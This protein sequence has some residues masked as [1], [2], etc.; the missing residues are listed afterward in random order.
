[1]AYADFIKGMDLSSF[2]AIEDHN[3]KFYDMNGNEIT[4]VFAFLAEKK[5]VNYVRLRLWNNPTLSF[6]AGDYCNLAHTLLIAPRIIGAGMKFLLDFHYSD[7]WAD[8]E[9][10]TKPE[11]WKDLSYDDLKQAMYDY[12]VEVLTALNEV[13]AFPDMVQVGNEISGGLLW[14]DGFIDNKAGLAGL[15]NT[16]IQAVR[17]ATPPG[18]YCKIM[19]HVA[20]GGDTARFQY[21]FDQI[22]EYG[23][24]DYD[25]V[26]LSYYAYWHGTLQDAKNNM[27]NIVQRYNKEVCIVET[28]FLYTEADADG[29]PNLVNAEDLLITGLTASVKNQKLMT[30]MTF[31]TVAT[32]N[33]DKGIGVFYWEP[34]WVPV[35]GVGVGKD[36]GN[37]WDNQLLFDAVTHREL[38]SLN[39]FLFDPATA[40]VNND[41]DVIAYS[42]DPIKVQVDTYASLNDVLPKSINVLRYDGTMHE[43]PVT[44]IGSGDIDMGK[45]GTY[46]LDGQVSGLNLLPEAPTPA[47]SIT[48]IMQRNLIKNPG[49]EVVSGD[50]YWN[51]RKIYGD[52]GQI[53]NG[54]DS[55]PHSGTGSFQYWDDKDFSV[56]V[57]QTVTVAPE[58]SY[59]LNAWAQG[60]W[61]NIV[62]PESYVF[63]RYIDDSGQTQTLGQTELLNANYG[64][65]NEF[66]IID[67]KIP[68]NVRSIIVGARVTGNAN[69]F[70]T[71]DDFELLD[72]DPNAPSPGDGENVLINGDFE[73]QDTGWTITPGSGGWPQNAGVDSGQNHTVGGQFSF[74]Y[75]NPSPFEVTLSQQVSGISDGTYKLTLYSYGSNDNKTAYV[76]AHSDGNSNQQD[77]NDTNEWDNG[78]NSPI[79]NQVILDNIV[80][81]NGSVTI[82][83][84]VSGLGDSW[85]Y[86]DDFTLVKK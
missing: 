71:L 58:H 46:H 78:T 9:T 41:K 6:D 48:V 52:A 49:F 19:I 73:A 70:G 37:E 7:F 4:D 80:V 54:P 51:I 74:H 32:V 25:V 82:S 28:G 18:R 76:S 42:P 85:G 33:N 12:T 79:W 53:T 34:L 65:W 39:S 64:W 1:M 61:A 8:P 24:H 31:N 45:V 84:Y 27:N 35:A 5:E 63:A 75:F 30:E 83:L 86:V 40:A 29:F 81:V 22:E 55:T 21:Y 67:I 66:T 23:V 56:E 3:V 38:D 57:Y 77:L 43:L 26:G 2:Q 16:G 69:G 59:R 47:P 11:A 60:S 44:W 62:Y 15:L 72:N 14:P 10:Q 20:E 17:D 36:E 50:V 68:V 13:G